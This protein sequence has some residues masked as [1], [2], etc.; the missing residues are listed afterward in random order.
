MLT[1]HR[2]SLKSLRDAMELSSWSARVVDLLG[3][4][5]ICTREQ[6]RLR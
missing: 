4:H 1:R 5:G 6:A 2:R 3:H